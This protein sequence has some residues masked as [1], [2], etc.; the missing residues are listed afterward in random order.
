L[1]KS[2]V[3]RATAAA[4]RGQNHYSSRKTAID[5]NDYGCS[6]RVTAAQTDRSMSDEGSQ[7][8]HPKSL[9]K[10]ITLVV[11]G[12]TA[13]ATPI[14]AKD[15]QSAGAPVSE[16]MTLFQSTD[17]VMVMV[18]IGDGE[19][20]PMVFD[21]GSDGNAID[22]SVARRLRL[23]RIGQV[24][25]V[26][27][28]SGNERILPNV[29]ARNVSIGGLKLDRI[30]ATAAPYDRDDAM[31]M[32]TSEL[33]SDSLLFLDLA[34]DRAIL[35]PR[36]KTPQPPGEAVSY[37]AGIPTIHMSMPDGSTLPAHFDTGYN[38][39]LSLPVG[40]MNTV[41][42]M[43]PAKVIGRFKSVS[44][45]GEVYGGQIKGTIKIGPVTLENPDV[46]F[47][48]NIANIGLPIIRQITLVIDAAADR[49]W[50]MPPGAIPSPAP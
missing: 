30:E 42:L 34:N 46:S 17:R 8:R 3:S 12:G 25:E 27:G 10:L 28:T 33:F 5:F 32:I 11:V 2:T 39:A 22:A 15:V 26:D 9:S 13:V 6:H 24:K 1:T 37:V 40:M 16:N 38:A 21:T 50:V 23:K 20:M 43:R 41:P 14:Y 29:V 44:A 47:L 48:G 31:G 7:M 4:K 36:G 18:R 49:A 35:A 19:L 45:E